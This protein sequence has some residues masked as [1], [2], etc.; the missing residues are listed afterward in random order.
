MPGTQDAPN[1]NGEG[2]N[3]GGAT[4][5][6]W[7]APAPGPGAAPVGPP[8]QAQDWPPA[9]APP[10]A[11]GQMGR[12][13]TTSMA[14]GAFGAPPTTDP[15]SQ[16]ATERTASWSSSSDH[17]GYKHDQPQAQPV[18]GHEQPAP[19][20]WAAPQAGW[21]GA[22]TPPAPPPAPPYGPGGAAGGKR[23][24]GQRAL[25]IGGFVSTALLFGGAGL[26]AGLALASGSGGA[27][28]TAQ[29]STLPTAANNSPN[30]DSFNVNAIA[31]RVE[32]ATVDVTASADGAPQD[33]GT[34]MVLTS[35]GIVLTNNHVVAG[36]TSLKAQ[37]NGSGPS[38]DATVL[39]VDPTSDVALLQLHGNNRFNTV[40]LG[41]SAKVTVGDQ[42]VA[43]GNAL[44]LSGPETVTSGIISAQG[45]AVSVSDP[46]SGLQENLKG[47]FQTSAPI[48]PGNSGGPLV[49]AAGQVIGMNTASADSA[50]GNESA[51]NVG[52]AIPINQ[53]MVIARQIQSGKA[54]STVSIGAH[55]IMG[56]DVVSVDCAETGQDCPGG[57][58]PFGGYFGDGYTPPVQKGAVVSGVMQGPAAS[59]GITEGDVIV[60]LDGTKVGSDAALHNDLDEDKVGQQVTV[61]WVDAQDAS[62]HATFKLVA[63]PAL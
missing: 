45:R 30:G 5:S 35:S 18:W 4:P 17:W 10:D 3:A 1:S 22:A 38:Y 43:I 7:A 8:G 59:A 62:H 47:L 46:S 27:D 15:T 25:L 11:T 28:H 52:F 2:Y 57:A 60:S 21:G 41:N 37:V 50:E 13:Q 9:P 53:A 55:A 23:P 26:G 34:G 29:G 16:W 42:V 40:T 32:Q 61:G 39:G 44:A 31:Q 54:T 36:S 48:N 14:A 20:G 49:D 6:A 51:S 63:G 24:R 56:V 19:A 58:D 33:E 12:E